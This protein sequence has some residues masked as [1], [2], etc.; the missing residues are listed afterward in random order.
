VRASELPALAA[1]FGLPAAQG[2]VLS[3]APA[4]TL[5]A[6]GHGAVLCG[7]G[8]RPPEAAG[9]GAIWAARCA[10]QLLDAAAACGGEPGG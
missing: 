5:A 4:L 3:C 6:V 8:L 1:R 2:A 10:Q 7:C 9:G